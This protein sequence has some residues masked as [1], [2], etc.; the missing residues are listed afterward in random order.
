[1]NCP[2][3]TKIDNPFWGECDL[4]KC[5]ENQKHNHCGECAKVPCETLNEYSYA[6]WDGEG[7]GD[8]DNGLR[9][10][11]AHAWGMSFNVQK[12]I[13]D[14]AGQ[15]A[16]GLREFFTKDAVI[17]WHDSNERFTVDEYIRANCEYPG[18]WR[19]KIKRVEKIGGGLVLVTKIFN[20][21]EAHFATSFIRLTNGKITHMDEYYSEIGAAPQWR[22]DMNIGKPCFPMHN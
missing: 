4:K 2:G 9:I 1:M 5:C 18:S 6:E 13:V 20:D 10:G 15:N 16:D 11:I 7:E 17:C 22:Q 12:F 8:G 21:E 3:C 19:G 14:V